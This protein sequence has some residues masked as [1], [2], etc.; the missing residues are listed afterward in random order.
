MSS[1][2]LASPPLRGASSMSIDAHHARLNASRQALLEAVAPAGLT[3]LRPITLIR[4]IGNVGDQLIAAGARRLLAGVRY[5]E[6]SIEEAVRSRGET[7]VLMGSGGWCASFHEVMPAALEALEKRYPRVTVLPSS[8]DVSVPA[9]RRALGRSKAAIF[10]RERESY[11]QIETLCDAHLALDTAFFFD[12]AGYIVPGSGVLHAYRGDAE[13]SGHSPVHRDNL[14]ISTA[15]GSLDEWLWA[16]ARAAEVHTDRAHVMIAAAMLGKQV[17]IHPSTSHKVMA[18]ADYALMDFDVHPGVQRS[19]TS[20]TPTDAPVVTASG[21]GEL[22]TRLLELAR[23]SLGRLPQH[24][25][26]PGEP[27]VTI[28]VLSWNRIEQITVCI[29]S[30]VQH[31]AIP[32]RL[33][34]ID[35]DSEPAV[36]DVLSQ[37][38]APHDFIELRL[39]PE[40][41]GCAGARQL[42]ADSTSTDY[43]A[44]ID[45]DAELFPG[46]IEH[47][48]NAL[49]EHPEACAAGARVVLPNGLLQFCGGDYSVR[50]GL[51]HF[52][53]LADGRPFDDSSVVSA[54]CRWVGGTTFACRRMLFEEFPLD[55]GMT[56]YFEDNEWCYRIDRQ[57]AF[58]FRTAADALVLHYSVSKERTGSTP[59]DLLRSAGFIVPMAHFYDQHGLVQHDLFGFVPELQLPDGSFDVAG[60]R[61]LLELVTAKGKEWFALQWVSGGL[62]SLFLHR[63]L[64]TITGSRWYR[65]ANVYW[66][67]KRRL[68]GIF[69]GQSRSVSR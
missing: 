20:L 19:D 27:R 55:L 50:D 11:R 34:V 44:F 40:N 43:L 61:L 59:N 18:I 53:P 26:P 63:R 13:A 60:A 39:L 41:L 36:Q 57:R 21:V 48:V 12:F 68:A 32:F 14:D 25:N 15:L 49:D 38:C 8:F 30:I 62:S 29:T 7:A 69:S 6:V 28:V 47:L 64:A 33:L 67:V 9:V 35:N 66:S 65:L 17:E 16:I 22:R 1:R 54:P 2:G 31:V 46:T 5:D 51:I 58:S 52:E 3:L 10:A 4:G 45:D 56:T 23:A 24:A 37:I 42:A